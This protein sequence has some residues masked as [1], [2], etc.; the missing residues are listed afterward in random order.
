MNQKQEIRYLI[1]KISQSQY[2]KEIDLQIELD[3]LEMLLTDIG[4]LEDE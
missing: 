4:V 1:E 2:D 3:N